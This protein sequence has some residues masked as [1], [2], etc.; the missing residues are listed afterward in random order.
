M[1][2]FFTKLAL[3]F[4]CFPL[5]AYPLDKDKAFE[6]ISKKFSS[7][8]SIYVKFTD[9]NTRQKGEILATSG[10]KYSILFTDRKIVCNGKTVW[11]YNIPKK[12]VVISDYQPSSNLS[13]DNLF[14]EFAKSY[15]PIRFERESTSFAGALNKLTLQNKTESNWLVF[16][17]FD[18]KY[19]LKLVRFQQGDSENNF[20][21]SF[22][23]EAI[24][25]NPKIKPSKF[26]FKIP[27]GIEV[28]D[29]R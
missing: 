22:K 9:N 15:K 29:L 14:L 1:K 4:L 26:E 23:I 5:I 27:K 28:I 17:Y 20:A 6:Q 18:D 7:V 24:T 13:L 25:L 16:V 19:N 10:G 3:F 2:V 8:S 11:N 21:G 12:Q